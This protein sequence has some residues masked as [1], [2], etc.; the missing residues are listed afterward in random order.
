MQFEKKRRHLRSAVPLFPLFFPP[1]HK[2]SLPSPLVVATSYPQLCVLDRSRLFN[3]P[4]ERREYRWKSR[5]PFLLDL[6]SLEIL[7]APLQ[8]PRVD[9]S[10]TR[11]QTSSVT[12]R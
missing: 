10:E 11:T 5:S 6:T 2:N 7:N 9:Y 4:S 8:P 1:I 12:K 3:A